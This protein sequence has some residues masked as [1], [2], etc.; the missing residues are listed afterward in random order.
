MNLRGEADLR[1]DGGG[2]SHPQL[3]QRCLVKR[4]MEDAIFEDNVYF[5]LRR[6]GTPMMRLNAVAKCCGDEKP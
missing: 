1:T 5:I 2:N 4:K 6:G 3:K